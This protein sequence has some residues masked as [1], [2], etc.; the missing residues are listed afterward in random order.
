MSFIPLTEQEIDSSE[1]VKSSTMTKIKDNFDDHELRIQNVEGGSAA[2]P[3]I[4][5]RVNGAYSVLG[6]VDDIL[7]TTINVAINVIGVRILI[8]KAGVSGDTEIDLKVSRAGGA[9]ESIFV[10]SSRPSANYTDGN[11]YLSDSGTIDES[12]AHLQPGDIL[13]LDQTSVQEGGVSYLVR[14]DWNR[15]FTGGE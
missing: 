2:F 5:L 1:P 3:A 10:G 4:I 11:D 6:A 8:D 15:T 13:R 7:K 14:I 9:Y 12:K